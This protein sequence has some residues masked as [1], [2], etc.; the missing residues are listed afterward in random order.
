MSITAPSTFRVYITN[1][2][3][4]EKTVTTQGTSHVVTVFS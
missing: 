4:R 1:N 2:D 3:L